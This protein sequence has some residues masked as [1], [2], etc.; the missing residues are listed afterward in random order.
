MHTCIVIFYAH[1]LV[2]GYECA[3]MSAQVCVFMCAFVSLPWLCLRLSDPAER[4]ENSV[5]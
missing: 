2:C 1:M 5:L 4:P 3:T